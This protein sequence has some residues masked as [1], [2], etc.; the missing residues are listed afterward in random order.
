[1]ATVSYITPITN[2]TK[3]DV[4]Y[5]RQHQ[6]DLVNKNIGAW[7]YTDLNRICNNLKYAAEH[8]YEQGFLNEPY[9][10]QITLNWTET[11]IITYE[12]LNSM[13]VNNMNNLKTYSRPDLSW[14]PISS[15]VN[16]D[17]ILA[18]A[19]ERNI[20]ALA[21]Q[22]PMPPDKFTL[23]VED[24]TG[25]GEYEARTIVSI[26]ANDAPE[27]M[28]FSRWS[29]DHLENIGSATAMITTYQMPYENITLKANYT[30]AV[31]HT[32]K[33]VT[34]SGTTT[35]QLYMGDIHY[36]EADP[37]PQDKVFHHWE[38]TPSEYENKLY[39]PAATTHFTMPNEAVTLTAVYITRGEKQLKV[40]NGNGSGYYEYDTY[41]AISSNKPSGATFTQWTGDTQYLTGP[42]TQEYN[43][44][45]IPD[46]NV[47]T[48][49][50][51]WSIPPATNIK[52]TVINGVIASTGETEGTFTEGQKVSIKANEVPEGQVFAGWSHNGGGSV[53]GSSS[54]TATITI[55]NS[56]ATVTATYRNLEYYTLT[57]NEHSGKTVQTLEKY[58]YF[59]V[60]ANPYPTGYTFDKWTGD[61]HTFNQYSWQGFNTSNPTTGTY[62]GGSDRTITA[63]YRPINPHTLT[64]KQLSGDVTY[65]QAEFSTISITAEDAPEGKRFVRW[66]VS[67]EGT[68]P[69]SQRY[70]K[71]VTYTFGNGDG[72]LTPVYVNVWTITVIDGTIDGKT[73]AVLDEGTRYTLKTRNLAVYEGFGG[74][75]QSGPGTITNTAATTTY[76][77][78]GA[79]DTTLT[80][81]I[82]KYPDKTLTVYWRH[83]TTNVDTLQ[84][85]KTYTYGSKITGIEAEIA[86]NKST[87]LTWLGDVNLL[88]PSALA[89][90]VS[91]NS[92]TT[93]TTI[94]ATYFY[95]QSPE[96]YTLTVYDGYPDP[97][98]D[99][100]AGSQV[101]IRAKEPAQGW[102][103]YTWYGDTQYLVNQEGLNDPVNAVIMPKKAITLYA[104]L[105]VIG[106]LALWSVSVTNGIAKSTYF[107]EPAPEE[108]EEDTREPVTVEGNSILVP[109]G[110]EV[111]LVA[112][113]DTVGYKFDRWEGNFEQAGVT[114]IV[115]KE[116]ETRFTMP[117]ADMNIKMIRTE[118]EVCIIYPTNATAPSEGYVGNTY[119]ISGNLM[120]TDDYKYQ[121]EGWS[122]VDSDGNNYIQCIADPT[123]TGRVTE[124]TIPEE[125]SLWLKAEYTTRYRLTVIKGQNKDTEPFYAEN[126]T[127]NSVYADVP[128]PES[129]LQFDHWDD[130]MG[131]VVN[132]YDKTPTIIM[133]D[134]VATIT[135]VYT[136]IDAAGNS[137]IMT[138]DEIDDEQILRSDSYLINGIYS[139]G[140]LVFDKEGCLGILT[141]VDPDENDDTDD[142]EVKKFFYGG[143]F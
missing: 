12:T 56:A 121:F 86:P 11:D 15:I 122:C 128:T 132:I 22:V 13:I 9:S 119:P 16:M 10:M 73:T 18:N 2:R 125:E 95:P 17:Y 42:V 39:E 127:I 142:F 91:I 118:K 69:S 4:E 134:T 130:P 75:T 87:F 63:N 106:E 40:I 96:Y 110:A 25:S 138:G 112:D 41:A 84:F 30:S 49:R 45:K 113:K 81:N 83:P 61:T 115:T 123:S 107:A 93:D 46:V 24:G 38:V 55:G 68:I 62:M 48:V 37:A 59:S 77:T 20:H 35:H 1:M 65:Q 58:D 3:A 44:V 32:L 6:N 29:G 67:G 99:Y 85:Q 33:V 129:R 80:A 104:K 50:A 66:D 60:D 74:W 116:P 23:T 31:P 137:V 52:L 21:T 79:G 90:T 88:S 53:S 71:T 47:I 54:V 7:N 14:Y 82:T 94:T 98:G 139:V 72:T 135:A 117:R 28:I 89:S 126:E 27:G 97:P 114:D 19:L 111:I 64:V 133:K 100:A 70:S 124:I 120:D 36:I 143:N 51:N 26:V 8:M 131:V 136:S 57:I 102:E 108:G 109:E 103:F 34:Y 5:A 101:E 78:V 140:A 76:F 141:K 92:L 43:S 105:K